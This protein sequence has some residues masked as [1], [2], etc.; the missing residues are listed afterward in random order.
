[1]LIASGY[2]LNCLR[3]KE[4]VSIYPWIDK[5]CN[6]RRA[7]DMVREIKI[8]DVPAVELLQSNPSPQLSMCAGDF[9]E[10]YSRP[11]S[12]AKWNAVV[13]CFFIDTAPVLHEYVETIMHALKPGGVWINH[14]PLLWHWRCP[15]ENTTDPRYAK[16][17]EF[18]F[19]E[20]EHIIRSY[21]F[22]FLSTEWRKCDYDANCRAMMRMSY[23]TVLFV[24]R[25]PLV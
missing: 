22:E 9:V 1:M 24:A 10:V 7:S 16:S 8:P 12:K 25:K 17:V 19:D 14:G 18:S 13:T 21:G 15:F 5:P 3:E 2:I 20:V 6:V 11:E 23:D 4:C